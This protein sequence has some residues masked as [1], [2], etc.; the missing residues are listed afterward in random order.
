MIGISDMIE[1]KEKDF[2]S[3]FKAPFNAYRSNS[4]YVSP[5]KSDLKRF[6]SNK[7]PLFKDKNTFTFFSAF[8]NG[9]PVGRVEV[10]VFQQIQLPCLPLH[11]LF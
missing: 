9:T 10:F 1:V 5:F 8:K 4:L 6:L 11:G 7:N 2:N 3:F